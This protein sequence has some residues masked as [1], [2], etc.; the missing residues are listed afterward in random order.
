MKRVLEVMG[1]SQC[2]HSSYLH[3]PGRPCKGLDAAGDECDCECLF[4]PTVNT[5]REI[6]QRESATMYIAVVC[7]GKFST[8]SSRAN[9][10]WASFL[11]HT[12]AGAIAKALDANE[13]WGSK[14]T[15]LVGSLTEVARPRRDYY[16]SSL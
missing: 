2:S 8:K 14:Y 6:Y 4:M 7:K 1:C 11:S 3:G 10:D 15:I 12:K 13:R 5:E 16:L 9:G